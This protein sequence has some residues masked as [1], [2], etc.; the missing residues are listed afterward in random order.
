MPS[1]AVIS[2]VCQSCYSFDARSD[3]P[4]THTHTQIN[5][6]AFPSSR[7][8]VCDLLL[9][10]PMHLGIVCVLLCRD[11]ICIGRRRLRHHRRGAYVGIGRRQHELVI[12]QQAV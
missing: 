11:F 7:Q 12:V 2:F 9:A 10:L 3:R 1:F 4:H 5:F 6:I 8:Q